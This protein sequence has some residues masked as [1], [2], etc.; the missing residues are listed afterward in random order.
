MINKCLGT[1]ISCSQ[2]H[3][4]GQHAWSAWL[5]HPSKHAGNWWQLGQGTGPPQHGCPNNCLIVQVDEH[6]H[7]TQTSSIV[8]GLVCVQLQSQT[9]TWSNCCE[10]SCCGCGCMSRR[11][12][13]NAYTPWRPHAGQLEGFLHHAGELILDLRER[14][15]KEGERK[16]RR[17]RERKEKEGR[18]LF[19]Y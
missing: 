18:S 5:Q 7:E 13:A 12:K 6:E 17:E 14:R 8:K 1:H 9:G 3:W 11:Q 16:K 4:H 10:V 19:F 2:I 15:R